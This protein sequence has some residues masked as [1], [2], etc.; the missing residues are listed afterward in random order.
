M[1]NKNIFITGITGQ[2]GIFLTKHLLEG[3]NV[4]IFGSSRQNNLNLFYKKL[5]YLGVNNSEINNIVVKKLDL[6]NEIELE[7]AIKEVRPNYLYNLT[8]P[9]SVNN[10]FFDPDNYIS[11]I[12]NPFKSICNSVV[13]NKLKTKIFQA[14]SSEMFADT[15]GN[16]IDENTDFQPKSPYAKSKLECYL[17][18]K[19]FEK[20]YGLRVVNG[21]LFNHESE[22]RDKEFLIMKIIKNAIK[23]KNNKIKNFTIGSKELIREWGYSNDITLGIKK[24]TE[25]GKFNSYVIGTGLG[26]SIESLVNIIGDHLNLEL[27]PLIEFDSS[28]LRNETPLKIVSNPQRVKEELNWSS[29]FSLEE[30]LVKIIN[31]LNL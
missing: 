31:Y 13:K 1:N 9:S 11:S 2:D 8:G 26:Y 23:I 30:M 29:K 5:S 22:F 17:L 21:F 12:V 10:S 3:G 7:N 24:I 4:K 27:L 14:S 6:L 28:I 25:E 16:L 15:K 20:I 19:K 18:S